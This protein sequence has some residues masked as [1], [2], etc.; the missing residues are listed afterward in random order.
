MRKRRRNAMSDES[1]EHWATKT[2]ERLRIEREKKE[3]LWVENIKKAHQRLLHF[4]GMTAEERRLL[5]DELLRDIGIRPPKPY[6][7]KKYEQGRRTM[8]KWWMYG[9]ELWMQPGAPEK[10]ERLM[11]GDTDVNMKD[12]AWAAGRIVFEMLGGGRAD[13]HIRLTIRKWS[14]EMGNERPGRRFQIPVPTGDPP[15]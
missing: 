13:S 14:R 5:E 15:L 11:A 8:A 3:C 10:L 2:T 12:E 6:N 4:P 7:S 1:A 9:Q